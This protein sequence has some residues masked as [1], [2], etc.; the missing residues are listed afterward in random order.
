MMNRKQIKEKLR[1]VVV[2]P[3]RKPYVKWIDDSVIEKMKVVKGIVCR[4]P[5]SKD[6][7]ICMNLNFHSKL[8]RVNREIYDEERRCVDYIK[9]TFFVV[10]KDD[11]SLTEEQA[12]K[13]IKQ[14]ED[15]KVY[16][17]KF[18]ERRKME[19]KDEII[20]QMIFGE[21]DEM[22]LK[23]KCKEAKETVEIEAIKEII[24]DLKN[25]KGDKIYEY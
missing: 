14:F 2:K 9:G 17:C 19:I 8:K 4:V 25:K 18:K 7:D 3:N 15:L 13:Y 16:G 21:I 22:W 6:T 23:K 12:E 10:S 1:V 24:E 11:S 20:N 5:F